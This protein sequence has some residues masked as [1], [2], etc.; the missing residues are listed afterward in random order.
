MN[1]C[2]KGQLEKTKMLDGVR[3]QLISFICL[4]RWIYYC[5]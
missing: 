5:L 4:Y 3:N 1:L 2:N